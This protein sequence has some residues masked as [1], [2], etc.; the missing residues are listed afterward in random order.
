M[1]DPKEILKRVSA[2]DHCSLHDCNGLFIF[3]FRVP[4]FQ[5]LISAQFAASTHLPGP[6]AQGVTCPILFLTISSVAL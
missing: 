2:L 4:L 5:G 1:I 3:M 6:G